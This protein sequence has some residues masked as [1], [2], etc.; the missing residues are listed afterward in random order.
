MVY[1]HLK[2]EKYDY[3]GKKRLGD[4]WAKTNVALED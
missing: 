4:V 3:S 1:F 2:Q